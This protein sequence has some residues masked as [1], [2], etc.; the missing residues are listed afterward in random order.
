MR[1][2]GRLSHLDPRDAQSLVS[3]MWMF[4]QEAEPVK[5]FDGNQGFSWDERTRYNYWPAGA[6]NFAALTG[7][8]LPDLIGNYQGSRKWALAAKAFLT[9]PP[10]GFD[11][12]LAL[13]C[14][15]VWQARV[16]LGLGEDIWATVARAT[17]EG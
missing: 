7:L 13:A 10:D 14:I 5:P 16:S 4:L 8:A 11:W 17:R 1:A 6:E 3:A 2:I 15:Q 9:N 12:A